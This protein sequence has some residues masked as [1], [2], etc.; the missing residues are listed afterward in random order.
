MILNQDQKKKLR[1]I[2]CRI[3][4]KLPFSSKNFAMIFSKSGKPIVY[5]FLDEYGDI[6]HQKEE[7]PLAKFAGDAV[8]TAIGMQSQV[9][10]EDKLV[11][12]AIKIDTKDI[13]ITEIMSEVFLCIV[14]DSRKTEMEVIS[15]QPE[16][17]SLIEENTKEI[18][19][20]L[21]KC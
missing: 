11:F 5:C 18:K 7:F 15:M 6:T 21:S 19:E 2:L 4:E 8:K 14:T 20:I 3:K 10:S 17:S 16:I 9:K 12:I 13:I 1:R